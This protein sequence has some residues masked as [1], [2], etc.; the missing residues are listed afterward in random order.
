[1]FRRALS[2]RKHAARSLLAA[3]LIVSSPVSLSDNFVESLDSIPWGAAGGGNGFPAGV[4]THLVAVDE[5][6]QGITY[7]ALFPAGS[8]F[9]SHWHSYDEFVTVLQG[10]V[11]LALNGAVL[12]LGPG[13]TVT[14]PGKSVH[15]WDVALNLGM[16]A[17]P[18]ADETPILSGAQDVILL[19]RRAGP[20]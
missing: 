13:G 16:S 19:V 8:H 20:R 5:L 6:T 9:S 7:Y 12:R 15:S 1:M 3:L 18:N 11:T 10:E 14:I 2:R 17:R 4:R